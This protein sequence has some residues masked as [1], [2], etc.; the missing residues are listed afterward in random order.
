MHRS[1][2]RGYSTVVGLIFVIFVVLVGALGY[3]YI[4]NYNA[5]VARTPEQS[6]VAKTA[7]P[8]TVP[9]INQT[10]DL[11]AALATLN[12]TGD[13]KQLSVD[14]ATLDASAADF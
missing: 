7:S 8:A 3:T 11:D 12:T 5:Q 10:A 9:E 14:L 2:T 1:F 4:T 6:K 13:D